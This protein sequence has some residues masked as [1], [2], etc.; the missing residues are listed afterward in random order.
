M[1]PDLYVDPTG[2]SGEQVWYEKSARG[3]EPAKPGFALL[4]EFR[5]CS[6]LNHETGLCCVTPD[7]VLA[8]SRP[9]TNVSFIHFLSSL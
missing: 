8:R 7:Q 6:C 3:E 4:F 5:P 2:A 1:V 9:S